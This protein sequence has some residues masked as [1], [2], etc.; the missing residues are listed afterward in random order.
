M[1]EMYVQR[2][3][4][5]K[6]PENALKCEMAKNGAKMGRDVA[7]ENKMRSES[8]ESGSEPVKWRAESR[9]E[10]RRKRE[11][12]RR[13]DGCSVPAEPSRRGEDKRKR[14][15]GCRCSSQSKMMCYIY[16]RCPVFFRPP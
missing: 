4:C 5:L 9:E 1:E 16:Y 10:W 13:E 14:R 12:S 8:R 7:A 6:S 15:A 11:E 3:K 2:Q